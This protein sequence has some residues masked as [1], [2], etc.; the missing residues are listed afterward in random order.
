MTHSYYNYYSSRAVY[1]H[2]ICVIVL[3]SVA[4]L[5]WFCA[6]QEY[7]CLYSGII[8]RDHHADTSSVLLEKLKYRTDNVITCNSSGETCQGEP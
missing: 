8:A 1:F 6:I 3:I 7:Y 4:T 2:T 5:H